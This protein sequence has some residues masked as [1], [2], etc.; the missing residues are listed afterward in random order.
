MAGQD[1][2]EE[3]STNLGMRD[4]RLAMEWVADNVASFGG[5]PSKVTVWGESAGKFSC[6]LTHIQPSPRK[7]RPRGRREIEKETL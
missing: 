5:D 3:G 7:S 2:A 4:Q 6:P 1:L